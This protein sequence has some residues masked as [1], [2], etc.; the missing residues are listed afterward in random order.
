METR[1][2]DGQGTQA[3]RQA[4]TEREVYMAARIQAEGTAGTFEEEHRSD[5]QDL[6]GETRSYTRTAT[7]DPRHGTKSR[8][9]RGKTT[10]T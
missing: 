3:R 7:K 2:R 4:R 8:N 5:K 9:S 10:R 6:E 1:A